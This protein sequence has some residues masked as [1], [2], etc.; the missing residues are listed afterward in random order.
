L[1][2]VYCAG[3]RYRGGQQ[4]NAQKRYENTPHG[5]TSFGTDSSKY[6]TMP[7]GKK[8]GIAK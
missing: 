1:Q 4:Q 2:I 5:G 8:Q 7:T 6:F 3:G